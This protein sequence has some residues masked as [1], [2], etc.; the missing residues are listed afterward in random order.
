MASP[1]FFV[2]VRVCVLR[3]GIVGEEEKK[4]SKSS[5]V[6]RSKKEMYSKKAHLLSCSLSSFSVFVYKP[7]FVFFK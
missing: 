4:N 6:D 2:C 1:F 7:T 3:K 5:R